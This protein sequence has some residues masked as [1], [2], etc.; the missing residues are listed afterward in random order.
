MDR[1]HALVGTNVQCLMVESEARFKMQEQQVEERE[2]ACD[3]MS[4]AE[5]DEV[6][7]ESFPS[8]DP[9]SWTL[10]IDKHCE[11]TKKANRS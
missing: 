1:A 9:P 7:A 10:G 5:I 6:F 4:E 3:S 11:S 8:S 2:Q